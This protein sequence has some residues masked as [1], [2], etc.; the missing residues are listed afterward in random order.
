MMNKFF[1]SFQADDVTPVFCGAVPAWATHAVAE[2]LQE[3]REARDEDRPETQIV[4]TCLGG[5]VT[6]QET[7]RLVSVRTSSREV[8]LGSRTL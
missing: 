2:I 4:L 6:V 5:Q 3:R 8:T 7:V 1:L